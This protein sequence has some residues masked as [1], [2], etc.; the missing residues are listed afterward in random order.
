MSNTSQTHNIPVTYASSE[1]L[2]A[3]EQLRLY[4][5]IDWSKY[6]PIDG[7]PPKKEEP[8]CEC[9][10]FKVSGLNRGQP[11]HSSWCPWVKE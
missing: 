3:Y 10:A 8:Q 5:T 4:S 9:G 1:P 6:M 7:L 11:G 2:K